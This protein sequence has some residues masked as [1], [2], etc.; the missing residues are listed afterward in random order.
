MNRGPSALRTV[1][2]V[3]GSS[4]LALIFSV[5]RVLVLPTKLG[6]SGLGVVTL[7]ISFTTF[8]GI[9]T[10]LGT[11][12]YLIRA[13]ARDPTSA[14]SYLSNALL[15]RIVM[16]IGVLA[17]LM[18]VA[19]LLGYSPETLLVIFIVGVSMVIFTL[20]NVFE[21]GLQGLGQQSWRAIGVALG[22]VVAT[23]MGVAALLLGAGTVIYALSIPLGMAVEFSV[24]LSYFF[25]K[26]PIKLSIDKGII[27]ALL[28]GGL[29]LFIWGFLQT[30][31]GQIDATILS[32]FADDHVVG[33]FGASSQ[34]TTVL[35]AIPIAISAVAMPMLCELYI[36]NGEQFDLVARKTTVTTLL[37][38]AP[39]GL[40]LA[41]SSGDVLR[42]LPYP[43]TFLNATPVL[44]LLALAM[45]VTA[46][47]MI[48]GSLAVATGQERQWVKISIFAVCI[49]PPLYVGLIWWFQT[50]MANGAIGAAAAN[51]IGESL[52][53]VW[54]WIVL[55]GRLRQRGIIVPIAQII[56]LSTTMVAAVIIMQRWHIPFLVYAPVAAVF[57][58]GEIWLMRLIT[59]DDLRIVRSSISRRRRRAEALG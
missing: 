59:P 57:Y 32:L 15:L 29:P 13:I 33:W 10:S 40:G 30:A 36:R 46:V 55:P 4:W 31:Y 53:L 25:L 52:L 21:A 1:L 23:T 5:L 56:W 3:L 27:R 22:Q 35:M 50:S 18:E 28:I 58:L 9:F 44:S 8:F 6:D 39:V 14:S 20:S 7:A 41:V 12:T 54:A 45:P 16:G 34:I 47:L 11:S 24:V 42:L 43:A 37:L 17:L 26:H 51:L 19:N 38:M 49:F 2:V 48:L